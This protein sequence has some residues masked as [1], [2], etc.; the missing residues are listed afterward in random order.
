MFDGN[1]GEK[2]S[3]LQT[4]KSAFRK[5]LCPRVEGAEGKPIP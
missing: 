5:I 1:L 4:R 2:K 3:Q